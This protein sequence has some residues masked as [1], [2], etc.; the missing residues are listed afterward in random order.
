VAS[1]SRLTV[2]AVLG[3]QNLAIYSGHYFRNVGFPWDFSMAYYAMVAFWTAALGEGVF[4]QWMP[5]QQMGYPFALQ[6]QSAMN[7]LPLWIFPLL[8]LPYTLHAA[9]VVQ[10]L[11]VL[12]GSIGMFLL[13]RQVHQSGALAIVAAMAFQFFGGFY[14]NAEHVDIVRAFAYAPWLLYVFLLDRTTSGDLPRRALLIP[15][16]LYL[17]LTGAYPG[18]VISAFVIIALFVGLQFVDRYASGTPLR[19]LVP[20]AAAVLGLVLLGCSMAVLQFAPGLLFKQQFVRAEP[21]LTVPR[22]SLWLE[23]LPGLFLSSANLPGEISMRSTYLSLPIV[24]LAWFAPK[25]EW[26]RGW[27]YLTIAAIAVIM[28]TGDRTFI[29]PALKAAFPLLGLSRFPSSDYRVFVAIPLIL[30]AVSGLRAIVQGH[31]TWTGVL[32]RSAL[33][34]VFVVWGLARVYHLGGVQTGYAAAVTAMALLI[35]AGLRWKQTGLTVIAV[36]AVCAAIAIDAVRV[37]PDIPGWYQPDIDT[38]YA[39]QRWPAYTRNRGRRLVSSSIFRDVPASRPARIVPTDLVRWS[40]YLNGRYYTTDLTPNVLRTT[41][42][43]ASNAVYQEYMVREWLPLLVNDTDDRVTEAEIGTR[44]AERQPDG[45]GSVTQT[46]YGVNEI[47]YQ[48]SLPG[49]RLLVENEMYFPGWRATLSMP[50]ADAIDALAVNGIFRGWRLPPGTYTMTA[51]FAFPYGW[52]LRLVC[53]ASFVGWLAIVMLAVRE[54]PARQRRSGF[55]PARSA[56]S[57]HFQ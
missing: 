15:P 37:L 19:A 45:D 29:G 31:V 33:G 50:G 25:A 36:S 10:C 38:Y 11:H 41:Q 12:G 35:I 14:S 55:I 39:Q 43:V 6:F 57:R 32:V 51:R 52:P 53:L 54:R 13:A 9:V 16:V 56:S 34:V 27:V 47:V 30:L 49:A 24:L 48:V 1:R 42:L 3:A 17:F 8:K 46:R 7:Y 5:F 18:N 21:L 2:L 4:P 40:G 44:L 28:T 23:H 20:L 26:R 22:E